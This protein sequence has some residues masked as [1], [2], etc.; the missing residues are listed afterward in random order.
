MG[1]L[2]LYLKMPEKMQNTLIES[3]HPGLKKRP[4]TGEKWPILILVNFVWFLSVF[5]AQDDRIHF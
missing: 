3:E 5:S 1:I 4:K 2:N